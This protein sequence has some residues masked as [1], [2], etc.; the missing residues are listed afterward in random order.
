MN[1]QQQLQHRV[2]IGVGG[3][4]GGGGGRKST[5]HSSRVPCGASSTTANQAQKTSTTT[6]TSPAG[7]LQ[8]AKKPYLQQPNN[9]N[10][11]YKYRVWQCKIYNFLERPRGWKSGIYHILM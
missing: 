9:L 8:Q 4:G 11:A 7:Q 10:R 6:T 1:Q 3:G 5:G 2:G